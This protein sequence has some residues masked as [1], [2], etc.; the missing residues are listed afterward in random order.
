MALMALVFLLIL[1]FLYDTKVFIFAL[2]VFYVLYDMMDGFYDDVKIFAAIRYLVP[3]FL[4]LT[5]AVK[6]SAFK[7]TDLIF[8]TLTLYLIILLVYSTGDIIVSIR[9]LMSL[10][11]TLLMIPVGR[12][13]GKR[14]NFLLEFERYN[15]FLLIALPFYI[16]IANI[17]GFG[18]SYTDEFTTGF[19]ITSRMYVVP[20]VVFL[21]IHYVISNKEK[22]WITKSVDIGFIL[23][24]ICIIIINTRRTALGMLAM[25]LFVYGLL[26][27]KIIFKMI[28]LGIFA[29]AALVLSY[30]LYEKMLTAQLEKRE[31][32]QNIDTYEEEGRVLETMYIFD[33]HSR[34]QNVNEI[35]FGITLF[36][37][38]DFGTRYF[39]R[40]R[41]IH[42]D[43]NMMFF[44]TG[45]VGMVMFA[46]FF[47]HYFFIGNRKIA[48]QNRKIY[49]P[50][51]VMFLI[52][53][54]PG[55]F[56]GT[57]T[58]APLLMLILSAVKA[59]RP[60]NWAPQN[61]DALK[62]QKEILA[63]NI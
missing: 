28:I 2:V 16:I 26:N 42:S 55:R 41:P 53:L 29:I 51:L 39:G 23:I 5:F 13:I 30:P 37:T 44:S 52:V 27:R 33:Y 32:I 20:I 8:F 50:M 60:E 22:G 46:L 11:L 61:V 59:W 31:R 10:L 24:N 15:R 45:L 21:A 6:E 12:T 38:Y 54:L 63:A 14:T 34:R 1:V 48:A 17:V 43:L 57:L 19:L 9:N 35:L 7:K 36:D 58:Y 56:I 40:D 3:L 62:E 25:S 4:L 18:E 49:Y 47:M